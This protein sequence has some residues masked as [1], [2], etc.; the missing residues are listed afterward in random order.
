MRHVQKV[1]VAVVVIAMLT[2]EASFGAQASRTIEAELRAA[3]YKVE[4]LGDIAGAIAD[5][6]RIAEGPDRAAAA[7]ALLGMA[8]TF[9]RFGGGDVAATLDQLVRNFADQPATVAEA[10]AM[11]SSLSASTT[12]SSPRHITLG[13]V[14]AEDISPDGRFVIGLAA[15]SVDRDIVMKDLAS[16]EISVIAAG[17]ST[18]TAARRMSDPVLSR[19]GQQIAFRS[20]GATG[21]LSAIHLV[22][23]RPGATA[24]V[25]SGPDENRPGQV[26]PLAWSPDGRA[27]LTTWLASDGATQLDWLSLDNGRQTR[28]AAFPTWRDVDHVQTAPR[29]GL[30]PDGAFIAF[31]AV[32]RERSNDRSIFVIDARTGANETAVVQMAGQHYDPIWTQSGGHLLFVS[33]RSGSR[34]LWA[35]AMRAGRPSSQPFEVKPEIGRLVG[36]TA[37]GELFEEKSLGGDQH[38]FVADRQPGGSVRITD[39][40]PG[41]GVAWKPDNSALA[42]LRQNSAGTRSIITRSL[43]NGAEQTFTHE[44]LNVQQLRW[45]PGTSS[46]IVQVTPAR[47]PK[48][49]AADQRPCEVPDRCFAALLDTRSGEF[50]RLFPRRT[51]DVVR[52]DITE[53]SPDGRTIYMVARGDQGSGHLV[54]FD[55][56][57]RTE[58]VV[59]NL[60]KF[61]GTGMGLTISPDGSTLVMRASDE[62]KVGSVR[63]YLV[64]TDG[65]GYRALTDSFPSFNNRSVTRWTADGEILFFVTDR[66]EGWRLMRASPKDGTIAFAGMEAAKLESSVRMPRI[67]S[68]GPLSLDVSPDG[69]RIAFSANT[70]VTRELWVS[71]IAA[72][73]S[74]R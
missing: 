1:V 28:I 65:S 41:E 19:D 40:F 16:G 3:E 56:A 14:I 10:R 39:Y 20:R 43:A 29:G 32:T 33:D 57:T 59:A 53:V 8:R 23:A 38:V 21:V 55:V 47:D 66:T 67:G 25:V 52:G 73:L 2:G 70:L 6:R 9:Q 69:T 71:S 7:R 35:V 27:L 24:R 37:A 11:Q 44:G 36:M 49:V 34:A 17:A 5:Y 58:R 31:S 63:L 51:G 12:T 54:A 30:S 68:I 18:P 22:A 15:T 45:L 74:E 50:A 60:A 42:F 48:M 64:P 61:P 4:V 62:P 13:D 46:L 72:R 26:I